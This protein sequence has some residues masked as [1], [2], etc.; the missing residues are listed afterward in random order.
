MGVTRGG[1][2]GLGSYN[3]Q[4]ETRKVLSKH[5]IGQWEYN[6]FIQFD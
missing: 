5:E 4:S 3:P 2:S 6:N 1:S